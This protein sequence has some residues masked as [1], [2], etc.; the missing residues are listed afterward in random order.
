MQGLSLDLRLQCVSAVV[1]S[2]GA[3]Y[4][5]FTNVL[6]HVQP[7]DPAL[8]IFSPGSWGVLGAVETC[9]ATLRGN[10]RLA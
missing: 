3:M 1:E 5:D 2:A 10:C 4:F 8:K 7:N 6:N 9:S